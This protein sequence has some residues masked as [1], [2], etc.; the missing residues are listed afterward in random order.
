MD[1]INLLESP[2]AAAGE[3]PM[4]SR[5]SS[6]M[7][8]AYVDSL[9]DNTH[10][11]PYTPPAETSQNGP[12]SVRGFIEAG[13]TQNML[14]G[15]PMSLLHPVVSE[16]A[17]S[18]GYQSDSRLTGL[19]APTAGLLTLP[20]LSEQSLSLNTQQVKIISSFIYKI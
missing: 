20:V 4:A 6:N 8:Y 11:T 1:S 12:G 10:H 3:I 14:Y 19:S 5:S 13:G 2:A 17:L 9:A 18:V 7:H 16:L 15:R